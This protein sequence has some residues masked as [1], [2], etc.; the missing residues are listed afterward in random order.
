MQATT[1]KA[2]PKTLLLPSL[3]VGKAI[4]IEP[5]IPVTSPKKMRREG[6]FLAIAAATMVTNSGVVAFNIPVSAE[7]T[8]CSAKGNMLSG[9]ANQR[10]LSAM[11]PRHADLSM[12]FLA[13]GNKESVAKPIAM[14]MNETPFGAIARRPSAMK[15]NDAPQMTPGVATR[16]QSAYEARL[17]VAGCMRVGCAPLQRGYK[18]L[19]C[20]K[21][22]VET[23]LYPHHPHSS[24][25][26]W[27]SIRLLT[28]GL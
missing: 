24:V 26:Q 8:R 25:A 17:S 20:V 3:K 16:S 4:K 5:A 11:M 2:I 14:R 19:S 18:I 7:D 28:G 10:T 9:N 27:Q 22:S 13:A 6:I 21:L 1:I 12:G 23:L 15:R